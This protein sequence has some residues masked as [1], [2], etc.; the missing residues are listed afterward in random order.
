MNDSRHLDYAP[1]SME[2][3]SLLDGLTEATYLSSFLESTGDEPPCLRITHSSIYPSVSGS[4]IYTQ[5][6]SSTRYQWRELYVAWKLVIVSPNSHTI[7]DY[8]P[9]ARPFIQLME[10]TSFTPRSKENSLSTANM[11]C[12]CAKKYSKGYL[13][14]IH[15]R[16]YD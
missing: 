10:F 3:T 8:Q 6:L 16:S 9:K 14:P 2:V 5:P 7:L 4:T 12:F 15:R 13:Y 1:M 11:M